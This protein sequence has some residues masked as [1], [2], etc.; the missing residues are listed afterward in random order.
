MSET[1]LFVEGMTCPSCIR[2]IDG[3]LTQVPGVEAVDVQL[4]EGKV[5]VR[6]RAGVD[7]AALIG[8]V[9]QAGY[10]AHAAR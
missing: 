5:L 9:V 4:R 6:H 1:C 8:A 10:G 7:T 3:A 2:H